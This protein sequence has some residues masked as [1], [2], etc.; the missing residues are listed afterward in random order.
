MEGCRVELG[1]VGEGKKEKAAK[2]SGDQE[3]PEMGSEQETPGG[4][5]RGYVL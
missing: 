1:A 4:G 3:G 5:E 2:Q